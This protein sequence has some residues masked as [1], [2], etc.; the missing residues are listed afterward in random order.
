MFDSTLLID[1]DSVRISV[2]ILIRAKMEKN[3]P[4]FF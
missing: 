3:P 1:I 2:V 4:D